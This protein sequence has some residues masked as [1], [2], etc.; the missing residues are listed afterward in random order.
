MP[1]RVVTRALR[2]IR[3]QSPGANER[4]W[5]LI[6]A[7]VKERAQLLLRCDSA[8]LSLTATELLHESYRKIQP[9]HLAPCT[10]RAHLLRI[11]T[12]A[13][14]QVLIDVARRSRRRVKPEPWTPERLAE[15][16]AGAP[17]DA[18]ERMDVILALKEFEA[19]N[20]RAAEVASLRFLYGL[21]VDE[22]MH[23]LGLGRRTVHYAWNEARIWLR[24]RLSS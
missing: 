15:I 12:R 21:S 24:D 7:W 1:P 17:L 13:M 6:Y 20:A 5:Q 10:D 16:T 2:E 18:S 3:W 19:V 23:V 11:I 22:V 9:H 8:K 4:L 14:R